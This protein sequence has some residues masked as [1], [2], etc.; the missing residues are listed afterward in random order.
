MAE[1]SLILS[2]I[3][4]WRL[5]YAAVDTT[6]DRALQCLG[7]EEPRLRLELL[8]MRILVLATGGDIE[9]AY[10]LWRELGARE[11]WATSIL[12]QA[13]MQYQRGA[14]SVV[15]YAES[16]RA[17]GDLWM[18]AE[19][20]YRHAMIAYCGRPEEGASILA[21]A[22]ATAQRVGNSNALIAVKVLW[23]SVHAARG[24]LREAQLNAEEGWKIAESI[25]STFTHVAEVAQGIFAFLRG[26]L[27]DA[28]RWFRDR[29]EVRTYLFGWKDSCLF[30]LWAETGDE[31]AE[32]AWR[33]RRW[34]LP[35]AGR[36]NTS[37]AWIALERSV[38]GL[39][40][41]GRKEEAAALRPLT[42]ELLQT[43]VW[44]T[45]G[46][47]PCGTA[48]GIAA[49]CAGDWAAAE[50]HHLTAI[51]QMD[52]APYRTAQPMARE[53]FARMLLDRDAAG[54]RAKARGLL[55]EALTMYEALE[56]PLHANRTSGRLAT[57]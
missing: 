30:A 28:E 23:A 22:E 6:I 25:Q 2:R 53:W 54:D 56:M 55:T 29:G 27:A 5:A 1:A 38:V 41:L 51:H 52:T 57:L 12:Y 10:R 34:N 14:A 3:Q 44:A 33:E 20:E 32:R 26:N 35:L 19:H 40:A 37:G 49:A 46:V 43:G 18:V 39:A 47:F 4:A 11:N 21:S 50:A 45:Y 36:I 8:S 24:E 15:K 16:W 31:R 9:A 7:M 13:S 17:A 48:A 42:E